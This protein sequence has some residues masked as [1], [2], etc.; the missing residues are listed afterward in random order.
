MRRRARAREKVG[1]S[2]A[3]LREFVESK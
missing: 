1:D 2:R 3:N